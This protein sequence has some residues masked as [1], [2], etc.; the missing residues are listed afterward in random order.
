MIGCNSKGSNAYF[1]RKDK[2]GDL[3]IKTVEEGYVL[4][5]F[6][7]TFMNGERISGLNRIKLIE[8]LDVVDVQTGKTL[9]ID[10]SLIEY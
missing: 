9:K 10:S 3:K 5:K 2:V 7:E 8:G 6:R 4:S 1:I